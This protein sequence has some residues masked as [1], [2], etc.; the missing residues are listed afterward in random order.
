M[1]IVAIILARGDSK[2]IPNKNIIDFCGK[3]LVVWSIEHAKN[4]KNISSV[5]VSSDSN[6]ILKIAEDTGAKIIQRPKHLATDD[7]TS[8]SGW[9]HAILEIE[10]ELN[11]IDLVVAIQT[12]N[13]LREPSDIEKAI[14]EFTENKLDSMFSAS[15]LGDFYIWK[16]ENGTYKSLNY[17]YKNRTRRQEF[18][19]QYVENGSFYIFKPEIL[20]DYNNRLGGKIGITIMEFWKSFEIDNPGGFELCRVLMEHY[21]LNKELKRN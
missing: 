18:L 13:P 19:E 17:D 4:T 7:S 1:N 15:L 20:K 2:G 12:T 5:W 11:K 3:P 10:K 16:K 21:I 8:E 6:T 9:L 14:N